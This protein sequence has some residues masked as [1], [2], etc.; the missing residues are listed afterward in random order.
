MIDAAFVALPVTR[1]NTASGD[2]GCKNCCATRAWYVDQ[3]KEVVVRLPTAEFARYG[4]GDVVANRQKSC[5]W[6]RHVIPCTLSMNL[7]PQGT[8]DHHVRRTNHIAGN[9]CARFNERRTTGCRFPE[10]CPN[11]GPDGIRLFRVFQADH[12]RRECRG[13]SRYRKQ[14]VATTAT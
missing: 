13:G 7:I 1:S 14:S 2:L 5:T 3:R 4:P 8:T 9:Q 6:A 11:P 12:C 10:L